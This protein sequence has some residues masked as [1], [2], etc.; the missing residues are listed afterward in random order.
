M[1]DVSRP[2]ENSAMAEAHDPATGP[3]ET[4]PDTGIQ[5]LKT[6]DTSIQ[7]LK[8]EGS[9]ATATPPVADPLKQPRARLTPLEVFLGALL[10]LL[11][12]F[13]GAFAIFNADI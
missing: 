10:L 2:A 5:A 9:A 8:Q 3:G 12:F 7:T 11:S 6:P 1:N 4:T 13:L